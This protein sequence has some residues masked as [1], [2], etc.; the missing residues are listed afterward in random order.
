LSVTTGLSTQCAPALVRSVFK[1]GQE[2]MVLPFTAPASISVHGPWQ[3]AA[4]GFL[5]C[6]N[7]RMK[8]MAFGSSRRAS[9]LMTPPGSTSPS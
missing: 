5:A 7:A 2:V 1:D 6:T 3:I 8:A 9:G 4:I